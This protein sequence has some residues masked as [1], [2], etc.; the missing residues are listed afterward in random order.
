M[1]SEI[2]HSQKVTVMIGVMASLLLAALD[3]TIVSTAMPKIVEEFNG[4]SQLSWVFTA[5]MLTSTITV[6]IYGKLSDIYGRKKLYLTAIVV[7]LLGSILSGLATS[8]TQLILFRALQGI[9][10]GALFSCSLAIIGDL[11]TP[12]ERG[13]WQG[14]FG[15]VFG[16]S[17]VVGPSLGGWITDNFSWRWNFFLNIPVGILAIV[18][19]AVLMPHIKSEIKRR[20][21][22]YLGAIT[23]SIGLAALLLGL[24]WGGSTYAWD[25]WQIISLLA[26]AFVTLGLF[27]FVES[28][29]KDAILP[30]SLFKNPIFSIS[31][32]ILFFTGLSMFGTLT[33]IPLFAQNVLGISAAHSGVVLTPLTF[34]MIGTSIFAGQLMSRTGKYKILVL[35]GLAIL[36]VAVVLLS[37]MTPQTTQLSLVF[38]MIFTGLGLGIL[39]PIFTNVV[40]NAFPHS[41]LGVVT[42]ATQL[43]RSLGGTVGVAIL[44]TVLNNSLANQ[45]SDNVPMQE[46]LSKAITGT[47]FI[48]AILVG[49]TF[50]VG[51]SL[52]EIPLRKSHKSEPLIEE[53]ATDVGVETGNLK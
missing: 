37:R 4:L 50:L 36:T 43:F 9:G 10:G 39:M 30:L 21:I 15:A 5:Y 16:L 28:R 7:F 46:A 44:G 33:Y 41:Q 20:T 53:I 11:F 6:P 23:L 26:V 52:K 38:H 1:L 12:A 42:A 29:A 24:V 19:I 45:L 48:S 2:P 18:L 14:V 3:Q 17:S 32:F 51:F 34:G 47:F 22:D 25:S 35:S 13:K 8:I 31:N 27:I 49:I 40:Q